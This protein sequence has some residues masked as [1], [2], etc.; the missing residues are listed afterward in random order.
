[1]RCNLENAATISAANKPAEDCKSLVSSSTRPSYMFTIHQVHQ[2]H[3]SSSY[4]I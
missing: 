2:L 3:S 1:M 4:G